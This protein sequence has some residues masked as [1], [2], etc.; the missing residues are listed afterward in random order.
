MYAIN[1]VLPG[2]RQNKKHL[3]KKY[4]ILKTNFS[5]KATCNQIKTSQELLQFSPMFPQ[6]SEITI[7]TWLFQTPLLIL[8]RHFLIISD[9]NSEQRK[10][11]QNVQS[12]GVRLSYRTATVRLVVIQRFAQGYFSRVNAGDVGQWL[13]QFPSSA[14]QLAVAISEGGKRFR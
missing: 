12:S 6:L 3:P 5:L 2:Q 1:P 9:L 13:N 10:P 4:N 14:C 8:A 7:C 11:R